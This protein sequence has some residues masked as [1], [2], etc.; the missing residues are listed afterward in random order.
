MF[1]KLLKN[2]LKAQFHSM[3]TIFFAVAIITVGAELVALFS[4]DI[5]GKVFGGLAAIL[6]LLFA[7]VFILVAVGLLYN[8]TMFGRA[9]YLTLTLPVKSSKLIW[10]KTVSGLIWTFLVYFLFLGATV[11]W[12]FQVKDF[13]GDEALQSAEMLLALFGV[14]TFKMISVICIFFAV[15]LGISVLLIIQ[16]MYLGITLSNVKPVSKLGVIGAVVIFFASFLIIQNIS[17]ALSEAFPMGMVISPETITFT[18]N[19]VKTAAEIGSKAVTMSFFGP[20]FRLV[21]AILLHFPIAY[22]AKHKV[23]VQ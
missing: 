15:A 16:T 10:S 22:F 7:C 23:N 17:T 6:T 8:K 13:V 19:T 3:S 21:M 9:G 11:L 4:D 1:G 5:V 14:P 20:V 12:I 18:S 2:D